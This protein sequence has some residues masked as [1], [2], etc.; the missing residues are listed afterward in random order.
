MDFVIKASQLEVEKYATKP[1][2]S[3]QAPSRC[4]IS[5]N[6]K[7]MFKTG[8]DLKNMF[9]EISRD[10]ILQVIQAKFPKMLPL[11]SL[12]YSD[13]GTV[14]FRMAD[15]TWNTQSM[16]EG[17][18][19]GCP[20]SSILAALVLHEVL[21]PI[22]AKLKIR[23]ANRRQQ[24]NT[25]DDDAGGETHP[26]A[27]IDDAGAAVPHEDV[28]FFFDEFTKLGPQFGCHLNTVKTRIMTSTSGSSALP[29][30]EHEYGT[31]IADSLRRAIVK[32]SVSEVPLSRA[33]A[34][35]PSIE[36]HYGLEPTA[37]IRQAILSAS[38]SA[39]VST[40][41]N[42]HHIANTPISIPM[43]IVTGIRLLGQPLGS[44]SFARSFFAQRLQE[45]M[46][47][48]TKLLETVSDH[49][50][51]LRL[52]AQCT[53]HKL[54]HLLGSEVLYCHTPTAN[55]Q[56]DD[57]TGPLATGINSMVSSFLSKLTQRQSIDTDSL[58]IAYVTIAQGG[59]G[60][61]DAST[62]AIPDLVLTMSQAVRHAEQGFF[63]KAKEPAYRLPP[64]LTRLFNPTSNPQSTFLKTFY[65]LLGQVALPGT[66]SQCSN[67]FDFF[68]KL[69]SL[70]SARDRLRKAA[71]TRRLNALRAYANPHLR[72]HLQDIL[73][74]ES[75]FPI[76]GMSRSLPHHR[77]PNE[78]FIIQLKL[79]LHLEIFHP[80][81]CPTCLCGKKVDPHSQHIF[82]C[83]NVSKIA[84]HNYIR[85][86][87]ALPLTR[88]LKTANIIGPGSKVHVEPKNVIPQLPG[89]RPFDISFRPIPSVKNT[90]TPPVPYSE[91]GIDFVVTPPIGHL[92][93][94]QSNAANN[95]PAPA[96]QHL[97]QK[98][99][100][101]FMRQ[102]MTDPI[103]HN[104]HTG[105]EMI[106]LIHTSG[107]LLIPGAISPLGNIGP[108]LRHFLYGTKPSM[109]YN[110]PP[111]RPNAAIMY[112][113]ISKHPCPNGI[114]PLAKAT[115]LK[116]KPKSQH[117]YGGSYTFNSSLASPSAKQPP[118]TSEKPL[119]VDSSR[120]ITQPTTTT[121]LPPTI[122]PVYSPHQASFP[123][124]QDKTPPTSK[125][126]GSCAV[127]S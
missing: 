87:S 71:S 81:N 23:A 45:N 69:G 92:P 68:L 21:A 109:P 54:P 61:M 119:M 116:N 103:N 121:C 19:Q 91:I 57:W 100:Q 125:P 13:P 32:Y 55:E 52:F 7:N 110:F 93:T 90:T 123:H 4:Y 108:L 46:A 41:A 39:G 98:E 88:L 44:L 126:H 122:L 51:A 49:Q 27:Y 5:F 38:V 43:E 3:G 9:N 117:F 74:P 120:R 59:L 113:L 28:E 78:L 17:V 89:A 15:G 62:R 10:K 66:H 42:N 8:V 48:A 127:T 80:N 77:L 37:P 79:K 40:R 24:Q 50:T 65:C 104:T 102:G 47:D 86:A 107:Q 31:L 64:S 105:D 34:Q 97:I 35:L 14:F 111:S 82:S 36:S 6:L 33:Q 99:R 26:M 58:L 101:K 96:A 53:L 95:N 1:Q 67:P 85:D 18:N 70:K 22:D 2:Q 30:I 115:W 114:V 76:I 106:G 83:V 72:D 63:C 75:S 84:M 16:A 94:S 29:A 11:V 25:G 73:I 20:L 56:W 124:H 60:L 118:F 12:L 112:N